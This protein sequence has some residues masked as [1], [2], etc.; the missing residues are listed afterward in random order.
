MNLNYGAEYEDFRKDVEAFCREYQGISFKSES[1]DNN[2]S[3]ALNGSS[4]TK[5][6]YLSPLARTA[7][8]AEL[9]CKTH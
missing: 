3:D 9:A 7:R 8:A 6:V 5:N 1:N 2:M 4:A